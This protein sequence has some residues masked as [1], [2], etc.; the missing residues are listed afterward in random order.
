M[1]KIA[2]LLIALMVISVCFLSGC[3]EQVNKEEVPHINFFNATPA[4]MFLG[5]SSVL[6]WN[7]TNAISVNIDNG[8][9][10]VTPDGNYIVVPTKFKSNIYNLTATNS[11]GTNTKSVT[12]Y[13]VKT[14]DNVTDI[15]GN[16]TDIMPYFSLKSVDDK[17]I[18]TEVKIDLEWSEIRVTLIDINSV[19][20]HGKSN[21][22]LTSTGI[23]P[24]GAGDITVGDYFSTTETGNIKIIHAPT[25]NFIG[26]W[27]LN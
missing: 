22:T 8:I 15:L 20:L 24:S 1:K 14:L 21:L 27:S 12:I 26:S 7:V 11:Y 4:V 10:N 19:I 5:N 6:D 16:V 25:W 9:G 3:N 23:V 2:I 17:L 13:V 18:V